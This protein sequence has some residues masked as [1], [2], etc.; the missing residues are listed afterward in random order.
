MKIL[1]NQDN[2]DDDDDDN[3]RSFLHFP[4]LKSL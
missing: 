3:F 2:D 1:K 4:Y